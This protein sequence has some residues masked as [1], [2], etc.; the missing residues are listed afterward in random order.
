MSDTPGGQSNVSSASPAT[1]WGPSP[2]HGG[3][4][5][6]TPAPDNIVS[7]LP[8]RSRVQSTFVQ[9]TPVGQTAGIAPRVAVHDLA[10]QAMRAAAQGLPRVSD[11]PHTRQ[12]AQMASRR[13]PFL[14]RAFWASP[15]ASADEH[16]H[17]TQAANYPGSGQ[18][19][20]HPP[21]M[22]S[23]YGPHQYSD[24]Q[25][26]TRSHATLDMHLASEPPPLPTVDS[27]SRG[28]DGS[29]ETLRVSGTF[30]PDTIVHH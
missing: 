12:P 18:G 25:A 11:Q 23:F 8:G 21:P 3:G 19:Q 20:Q 9:Q 29:P 28:G 24:A 17:F 7:Q 6:L 1:D 14:P 4:A 5:L 10:G 26:S 30:T 2:L 16:D 27:I 15:L 13:D 22:G